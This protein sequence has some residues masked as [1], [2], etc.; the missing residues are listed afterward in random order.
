MK[1]QIQGLRAFAAAL[2]VASHNAF[3]SQG[4]VA[5]DFF[6]CLSGFLAMRP[7]SEEGLTFNSIKDILKYYIMKAKRIIP[8]YYLVLIIIKLLTE[9]RW[10]TYHGLVK[11]LLFVDCPG[12]LWFVQQ[13][14]F[15]YL[16][17]PLMII[18]TQLFVQ[19]VEG[20]GKYIIQVMV[21]VLLTVLSMKFL[22][23]DIF[24]LYGNG[25]RM[26]FMAWQYMIGMI[27][28]CIFR[29]MRSYKI[30]VDTTA[31]NIIEGVLIAAPILSSNVILGK[32][33][34]ELTDYYI[35]WNR[36]LECTIIAGLLILT[37]S[38]DNNQSLFTNIL[39]KK[40]LMFLGNLSYET[41]II[42]WYFLGSLAVSIHHY[43]NFLIVYIV[44][45]CV[46]YGLNTVLKEL[47]G[48]IQIRA[49]LQW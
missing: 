30:S 31:K 24:Y 1:N 26:Q 40:P 5:V 7:F 49:I 37:V 28:G 34:P 9:D 20:S 43:K 6:F 16:V 15:M 25:S 47:K 8:P 21:L 39:C 32:I 45:I 3:L 35:G 19:I 4:G 23:A 48:I 2:V 14:V 36:P 17:T 11:A 44:T 33:N 27:F 18:A 46:S 10:F 22:T 42:H 41:Y 29:F 12:H 13:I 38:L